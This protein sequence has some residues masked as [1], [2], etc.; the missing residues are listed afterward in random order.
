MAS[1]SHNATHPRIVSLI[2]SATEIV[3]ALGY[4]HCLVGR[5]HECDE[6]S[7]VR[8]LPACS[9][10]TIDTA[11]DSGEI[12]RQVRQ[13]MSQD[14]GPAQA[15]SIYEIDLALLDALAPD[16]ILTQSQCSVCAVSLDRV[17]QAVGEMLGASPTIVACEPSSLEDVW[18]D[19]T[20]IA[21]A[22]GDAAAGRAL[23]DRLRGAM[24]RIHDRAEQASRRPQMALLEWLDPVMGCGNWLPELVEQVAAVNVF[25]QP[26]QHAKWLNFESLQ[27]TRIDQLVAVPCGFDLDRTLAELE[28][29]LYED[30]WQQLPPVRADQ[31]FAADGHSYFNRP[32]PRLVDSLQILAEIAH[33]ELFHPDHRGKGWR[34]QPTPAAAEANQ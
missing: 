22:I 7:S 23:V 15:L 2:P 1:Q 32:G 24:E 14:A 28:T 21:E 20:R 13:H 9:G 26:G 30:R 19:I 18:G 25:G 17:E 33:P 12:H 8:Q 34:R 16:L 4:E 10:P 29:K 5:S 31:L 27:N 3:A 6:P 11:S